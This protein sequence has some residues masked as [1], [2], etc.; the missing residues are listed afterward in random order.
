VP[1]HP[2]RFDLP[3]VALRGQRLTP[4]E[5][6]VT[7]QYALSPLDASHTEFFERSLGFFIGFNLLFFSI[8]F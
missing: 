1:L 2:V 5:R 3:P 7:P 6:G 4:T 8:L